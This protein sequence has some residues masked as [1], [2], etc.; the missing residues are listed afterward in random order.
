MAE[1]EEPDAKRAKLDEKAE[2]PLPPT[3]AA[4]IMTKRNVELLLQETGAVVNWDA[5]KGAVLI[6][7]AQEQRK[8]CTRVLA[9]I[10]SHCTWGSNETKVSRIIKP[11]KVQAVLVRLS[12]MGSLRSFSKKLSAQEPRLTIG[13]EKGTNDMAVAD[14]LLS[15]QHCIIEF[16]INKGAVYVIDM[17]TNGSYLNGIRLPA[18]ASGKVM[19]SHGDDLVLKDEKSDPARE[20]GWI[21]NITELAIGKEV[22]MQAPRRIMGESDKDGGGI[23]YDFGAPRCAG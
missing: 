9:R 22:I 7:G 2:V 15:R 14:N 12:P 10:S 19:L 20:F 21:L 18:K 4:H 23:R 5:S 6:S 3:L 17:S 16:D 13:K 1:S 8:A 11:R